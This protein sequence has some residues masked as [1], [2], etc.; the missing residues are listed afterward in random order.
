MKNKIK[1]LVIDKNHNI[2]EKGKAF[3]DDA[4]ELF[5]VSP[6]SFDELDKLA[7]SD[8]FN[9]ALISSAF[10]SL[11]YLETLQYVKKT[12]VIPTIALL[13]ERK[14]S[15]DKII[16][17]EMGADNII[18]YP[19][20][21]R[22][23]VARIKALLRLVNHVENNVRACISQEKTPDLAYFNG[24]MLDL[25]NKALCSA[26][27]KAPE[28]TVAEFKLL[29]ALCTSPKR[30][31]CREKL[32]KISHQGQM[33]A[34]NDRSIDILIA[35]L[36]KKLHDGNSQNDLIKTV[37]GV[38]YMLNAD[39]HYSKNASKNIRSQMDLPL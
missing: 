3:F 21:W 39:V 30:A 4:F 14:E 5:F 7:Q 34:A 36:R 22:E 19:F 24:W 18:T 6:H 8:N 15:V 29:K 13:D 17:L 28:L 33:N 12:F 26:T 23:L 1:I 20:E 35:R 16:A 31:I 11:D 32:L 2:A 10:N 38:G 9:L 25:E 37:R 27:K